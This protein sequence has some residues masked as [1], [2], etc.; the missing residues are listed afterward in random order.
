[1]FFGAVIS[2]SIVKETWSYTCRSIHLWR[3]SFWPLQD[4]KGNVV[5][6]RFL[7]F[8]K[9]SL[10]SSHHWWWNYL[11]VVNFFLFDCIFYLL[12]DNRF[13]YV[14]RYLPLKVSILTSI[15]SFLN[16]KGTWAVFRF[17]FSFTSLLMLFSLSFKVRWTI[18]WHWYS[19]A[20][21]PMVVEVSKSNVAGFCDQTIFMW[22]RIK[23][24]GKSEDLRHKP[25][26]KVNI[27]HLDG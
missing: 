1:M 14:V 2:Q 24:T 21:W 22:K 26:K 5:D 7:Y 25:S 6:L 3:C 17:T 15:D 4:S 12:I 9:T 13:Y 16:D 19:V 20:Y 27:K 10:L 8:K 23:I 18:R 11:C